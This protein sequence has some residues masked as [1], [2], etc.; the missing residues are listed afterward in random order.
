[1]AAMDFILSMLL[2]AG[3]LRALRGTAWG[4]S[5]WKFACLLF[6]PYQALNLLHAIKLNELQP[7]YLAAWGV[8]CLYYV[9]SFWYLRRPQIAALFR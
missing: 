4:W 8:A 5:A 9:I 3:C 6:L 2:L 1:M 7:A